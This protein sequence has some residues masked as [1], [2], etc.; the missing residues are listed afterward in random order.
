MMSEA[1]GSMNTD[2][3]TIT[4][5]A[6]PVMIPYC[7]RASALSVPCF[8]SPMGIIIFSMAERALL[9]PALAV[10]GRAIGKARLIS[11][12]VLAGGADISLFSRRYSTDISTS[13]I[14]SA[15]VAPA[16]ASVTAAVVQQGGKSLNVKNEPPGDPHAGT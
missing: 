15:A 16:T 4:G 3:N 12:S 9:S 6:I 10:H 1:N 14:P 2:G 7:I 8:I 11:R 13:D 5:I